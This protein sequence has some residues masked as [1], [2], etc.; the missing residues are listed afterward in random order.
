KAEK[1]LG[2]PLRRQQQQRL[3]ERVDDQLQDP[4]RD[5]QRDPD[6]QSG[7]EIFPHASPAKKKAQLA[8]GRW[9]DR[10]VAQSPEFAGAGAFA[11]SAFAS[12]FGSAF[13][14]GVAAEVDS[15]L[16]SPCGPGLAA[17]GFPAPFE[18]VAYHPLPFNWKPAALTSL[19]NVA[20][21]QDGEGVSGA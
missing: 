4:D 7:D 11:G 14:S 10:L 3:I 17:A 1:A 12:V 5:H 9:Q 19:R 20:L 16:A 18:S 15:A 6:Q 2:A 13:A 21:P 8:L